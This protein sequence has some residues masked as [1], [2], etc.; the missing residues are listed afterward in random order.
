MCPHGEFK[1]GSLGNVIYFQVAQGKC[2][3]IAQQELKKDIGKV[4]ETAVKVAGSD[5]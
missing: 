5:Q 3:G 2:M 4:L 1:I